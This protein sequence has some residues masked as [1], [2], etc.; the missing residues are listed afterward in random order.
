MTASQTS[1]ARP[2]VGGVLDWAAVQEAAAALGA[3]PGGGL[4]RRAFV[5]QLRFRRQLGSFGEASRIDAL[6]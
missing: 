2:S 6:P 5:L 1:T 4:G 3:V